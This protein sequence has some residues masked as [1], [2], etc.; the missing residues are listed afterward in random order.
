MPLA[1]LDDLH[2][3]LDILGQ[4]PGLQLH[5]QICLCFA[6]AEG[7][8]Q[9][10]IVTKLTDG[11]ER[12]TA[13]FPWLAGQVVNEGSGEGNS[14]TFS[15]KS[16]G[17]A[18]RLVVKD[19]TQ[20]ASYPTMDILREARFPSC[21]LD[22]NIVA[23]CKTLPGDHNE[24]ASELPVFQIQANFIIG[25]LILSFV[26]EHQAMDMTGQ[27]QIMHLL[28]KA[29]HS[30]TF[31]SEEILYGNLDR[32]DL[33]PMHD[34]P[35][36][37][38][39]EIASQ[40]KA[41]QNEKGLAGQIEEGFAGQMSEL[42]T[43]QKEEEPAG[44]IERS[45]TSDPAPSGHSSRISTPNSTW[46]YFLFDSASLMA[47]K[48]LTTRSIPQSRAY[49]STD[50]AIS[51]FVWQSVARARL[52]RL[53]PETVTLFSRPVNLRRYLNIPDTY[54]GMVVKKTYH[55]S[56]LRKLVKQP[57]GIVA[58]RLR[59]AIDFKTSTL[60][61]ETRVLATALSHASDKNAVNFGP[62]KDPGADLTFSSW[63]KVD[64]HQLDFNLGLGRPE[65]VRRPQ[66]C[67][68]EGLQYLMPRAPDGGMALLICL[69][70][71]D[72]ERLKVDESFTSYAS[73]VG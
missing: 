6:V 68:I 11:L 39:Q 13:S 54:P 34:E 59:S 55:T 22:E 33:F 18:P 71:E 28:S 42:F 58:S 45:I 67:P 51:A 53:D 2:Y 50:D 64:C 12:L 37:E 65:S 48:S 73:Y 43:D 47:L 52:P 70:T 56:T 32:R 17:N 26:G 60:A 69:R 20:D 14:G 41:A 10:V 66:F 8:P 36:K 35:S 30:K 4:Q 49:I 29:C 25:G 27:G 63:A 19:L 72:M 1:T 40:F 9:Q 3:D 44:Q 24:A 57:L 38:I 46:A 7:F 62:P 23:P 61:H 15:I 21:M 5:T 31:T 16:L